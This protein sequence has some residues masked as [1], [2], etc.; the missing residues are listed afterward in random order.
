MSMDKHAANE[1]PGQPEPDFNGCVACFALWEHF[2]DTIRRC[3]PEL[4]LHFEAAL[5]VCGIVGM[6]KPWKPAALIYEGL[7]GPGKSTIIN[8]LLGNNGSLTRQMLYRSDTFTTA[9]FVS[10]AASVS[11]SQLSKVDLLPRIKGKILVTPELAP[12]FR[13]KRDQL[14]GRFGIMA[15]V[16]DGRGLMVD[17]GTHGRRGYDGDFAFGWIGATTYLPPE[18]FHIMANVGN[19]IFFFDMR[20][21]RPTLDELSR[22]AC[23][24]GSGK[25]ETAAAEACEELLS[26]FYTYHCAEDGAAEGA[27]Q[28]PEMS[29][30]IGDFI[31][32]AAWTI[33]RL[34][35]REAGTAEYEYRATETL[36][37]LVR[38]RAA[39]EGFTYVLPRHLRIIRHIV[40]SSCR[41][42]LRP[43]MAA[44]LETGRNH[45]RV[46]DVEKLMDCS[47]DTALKGMEELGATGACCY[48]KGQA[49]NHPSFL[50]L[51]KE[52]AILKMDLS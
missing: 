31:A 12:L 5:A 52:A 36:A 32:A 11:P 35:C 24:G 34:R 1:E 40:A 17:G 38:S 49:P 8:V 46:D 44:L 20:P 4:A 23:Q 28:N 51:E 27:I 6:P 45:V 39:I 18:A 21:P 19:R 14:E 16:L 13:G 7:S 41:W 29:P 47:R 15:R 10:Q 3:Y 48:V 33:A 26:H 25:N 42:R 43:V 50:L 2:R 22:L 9:A 37:L 30:D